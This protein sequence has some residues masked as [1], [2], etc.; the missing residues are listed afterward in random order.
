MKKL[1]LLRTIIESPG[2]SRDIDG[3]S[4]LLPFEKPIPASFLPPVHLL[5]L[6]G[7]LG[8]GILHGLPTEPQAPALSLAHIS[9]IVRVSSAHTG[10]HNW[11]AKEFD[12]YSQTDFDYNE[13]ALSKGK[14]AAWF[15]FCTLVMPRRWRDRGSEEACATDT[16]GGKRR[17]MAMDSLRLFS[18]I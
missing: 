17:R 2:R 11:L 9:S 10:E 1:T 7:F 18:D 3:F 15:R 13:I 8:G 14:R 16:A 5:P 6:T 12:W 4:F